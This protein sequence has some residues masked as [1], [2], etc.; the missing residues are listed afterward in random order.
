M[1]AIRSPSLA[2]LARKFVTKSFFQTTVVPSTT[3]D[4]LQTQFAQQTRL[5][6]DE[7]VLGRG[8]TRGDEII[9]IVIIIILSLSHIFYD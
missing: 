4:T 7:I 9:I 6:I 3:N 5:T 8:A 2:V 1:C